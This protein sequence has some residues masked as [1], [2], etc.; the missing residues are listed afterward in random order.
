MLAGDIVSIP[1]R[2]LET[3]FLPAFIGTV[4]PPGGDS[5][6]DKPHMADGTFCGVYAVSLATC[7]AAKFPTFIYG[8]E[9]FPAVFTLFF[10]GNV[11]FT[12]MPFVCGNGRIVF[13]TDSFRVLSAFAA[14]LL[15]TIYGFK[16]STADFTDFCGD[17]AS[18]SFWLKY[19]AKPWRGQP[20]LSQNGFL[21]SCIQ[22]P[23]HQRKF[24]RNEEKTWKIGILAT[25]GR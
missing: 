20:D 4:A 1:N 9:L 5:L 12:G 7:L 2:F 25:T 21:S 14:I 3:V 11:L 17:S 22:Q 16:L 18:P 6:I 19:T 24:M 13:L 15:I 10:D 8:Q 23:K